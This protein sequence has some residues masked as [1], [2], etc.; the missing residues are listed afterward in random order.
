MKSGNASEN[1]L[2]CVLSRVQ[3]SPQESAHVQALLKDELSW[4]RI[5]E[6]GRNEGVTCLLYEHLK[7]DDFAARVPANILEELKSDYYHTCQRNLGIYEHSREIF[8]LLKERG[9]RFI[10]LKGVYL[11]SAVYQNI[12]LRPMTDIDI[13]IVKDDFW[14]AKEALASLDYQPIGDPGK[15]FACKNAYALTYNRSKGLAPF[16]IDVHWHFLSAT[17][18]MA[19]LGRGFCLQ[20]VWDDSQETEFEGEHIRVLSPEHQILYLAQHAFAHSF[21]KILMLSDLVETYRVYSAKISFTRLV[22]AAK[23]FG[24]YDI[25]EYAGFIVKKK[26]GAGPGELE[27]GMRDRLCAFLQERM[28]FYGLPCIIYFGIKKI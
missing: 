2:I 13:M 24:L 6:T 11:A 21:E 27:Y 20:R 10:A 3:L 7:A 17:W 5:L 22:S 25:L 12:G 19:L 28:D 16:S 1:R 15:A 18:L 26:M 4:D 23:N 14:K 9:I 8:R